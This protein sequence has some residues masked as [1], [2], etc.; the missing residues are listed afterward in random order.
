MRPLRVCAER[1]CHELVSIGRCP[2]HAK[3]V[4]A[5]EQRF[6]SGPGA[7]YGRRWK[8]LR[9]MFLDRHSLCIDCQAEGRTRLAD[10]VDHVIPHRGDVALF[11]DQSNWAPRC[12]SHHSAKTARETFIR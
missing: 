6:C 3:V 11:W 1:G 7:N 5:H 2:V 12:K 4:R 9:R 10:E 8:K